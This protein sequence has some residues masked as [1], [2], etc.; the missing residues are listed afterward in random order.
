MSYSL[1]RT[2]SFAASEYAHSVVSIN[3]T[4]RS[5]ATWF[6]GIQQP[7]LENDPKFEVATVAA[8]RSKISINQTVG[9]GRHAGQT[10]SKKFPIEPDFCRMT[11]IGAL[12]LEPT[13]LPHLY[14]GNK[15]MKKK[16][17]ATSARRPIA[18]ITLSR[19]SCTSGSFDRRVTPTITRSKCS[20]HT[21]TRARAHSRVGR[22]RDPIQL[23][24]FNVVSI[25]TP[26]AG[27][28]S[29]VS[30]TMFLALHRGASQR[31]PLAPGPCFQH[32]LSAFLEIPLEHLLDVYLVVVPL[33]RPQH[34]LRI[35]LSRLRRNLSSSIVMIRTAP[36]TGARKC[37]PPLQQQR[38]PAVAQPHPNLVEDSDLLRG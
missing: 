23:S 30:M 25:R 21:H 3:Q 11:L 32:S 13:C 14:L 29:Q 35:L 7:T 4:G 6:Q 34:P 28:Q 22:S 16:N 24:C 8:E 1:R 27:R 37:P 10:I 12:L 20:T 38:L 5:M 36:Y 17:R 19:Y 9:E 15:R 18:S 33:P 2:S 31:L 26:S